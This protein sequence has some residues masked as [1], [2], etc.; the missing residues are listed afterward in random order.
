VISGVYYWEPIVQPIMF[1][2]SKTIQ[3]G[4]TQLDNHSFTINDIKP[5]TLVLFPSYLK[6]TV[7][8]N[9]TNTPRR[10]LAFNSIPT[11]GFG[12]QGMLTEIN[13]I[14]LKNKLISK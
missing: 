5:G 14:R 10:S 1:V 6:H 11:T 12:S 9:N 2:D 8:V 13:L 3:I 7:S 4:P